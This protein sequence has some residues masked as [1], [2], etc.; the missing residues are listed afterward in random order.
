MGTRCT[1]LTSARPM[2]HRQFIPETTD[3]PLCMRIV[4]L[5]LQT[6]VEATGK[7]RLRASQLGCFSAD[8]CAH[9]GSF[10]FVFFFFFK[11][12]KK[13]T[14]SQTRESITMHM[15]R[16]QAT[17]MQRTTSTVLDHPKKQMPLVSE[18]RRCDLNTCW[19]CSR[20]INLT[21]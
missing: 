18:E 4:S 19:V 20:R 1:C 15:V 7:R 17:L 11:K 5:L 6:T 12:K 9:T 21:T 2:H 3:Y 14:R 13:K 8:D 16:N 10:V